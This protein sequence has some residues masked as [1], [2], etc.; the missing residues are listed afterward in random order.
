VPLAPLARALAPFLAVQIVVLALTIVY[1]ALTH[2]AEP[3]V[4]AQA[5]LSNDEATKRLEEIVPATPEDE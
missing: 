3:A 1:P 4:V 2:L 5:P